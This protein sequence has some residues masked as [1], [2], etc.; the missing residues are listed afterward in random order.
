[1]VNVQKAVL[2]KPDF[3][4][5]T[6]PKYDTEKKIYGSRDKFLEMGAKD[7]T[8]S[9]LNE[10]RLLITDTT[11]RDAQQSLMATRMRTKDLIGASDATNAFMENAF[12]VEAWGGATYDT[13]FLKRVS[14][15]EIKIIKTTYAKY[16]DP[17]VTSSIQC[18]R[19]Q[20]LSR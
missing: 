4:A 16:I 3:E 1:M 15:E 5:R 6:L 9:L 7:F 10:K 11:M 20:Q 2:D 14:M 8:Q 17:D 19:I 18:C 13:S 12:S